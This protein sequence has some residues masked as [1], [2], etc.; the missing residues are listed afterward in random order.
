MTPRVAIVGAGPAGL[1]AAHYLKN[2]GFE[3][4][5]FER[6]NAAGGQWSGDARYSGVWPSMCTSTSRVMT[7]FSDLEHEPGTGVFPTNQAIG[8]YLQRYAETFGLVPHLRLNTPVEEITRDGQQWQVRCASHTESFSHV[9]VASGRYNKPVMP[10]VP[11]LESFSGSAGVIHTWSYEQPERYRGLRVL[12]AGCG[13][14]ALEIASDVAM[15]GAARVLSC[16]RRQRYILHKLL[17]GVP[18][19]QVAFNRYAALAER[20]FPKDVLAR[21]FKELVIR[22]SGS[23][24]QFGAFRPAENVFDAGATLSQHFL[25]L[26][27]ER[28]IVPKPWIRSIDGETVH[29]MD[30]T[31]EDVDALIFG[32][33]YELHLPFLSEELQQTLAIGRQDLDLYKFTFHPDLPRMAFMGF[34][35]LK[36]AYFPVLELQARWIA[37]AWSGVRS[38]P[39]ANEMRTGLAAFRTR[40]GAHFPMHAVAL[41]F[42]REAGVEP[43]LQRWPALARALLFGPLTPASFRLSGP[44]SLPDASQT[45]EDDARS[46]GAVPNA[47]FTAEQR[48]QLRELAAARE[49]PVFAEFVRRL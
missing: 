2:E 34:F 42:A 23:P 7:A 37:Y 25:P 1:A 22:T 16:N 13:I 31:S 24:E 28:R 43:E 40:R 18:A 20:A 38:A 47:D 19:D 41:M 36:G 5:V 17:A 14:S 32:T 35:G 48:E 27:A 6:G 26:V 45:V 46:F 11:G 3:P 12:V 33:G 39:T 10:S 15:S 9:I 21:R 29:F 8:A 4:V 44:D 49:D 30:G